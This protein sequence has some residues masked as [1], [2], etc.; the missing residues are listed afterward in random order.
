MMSLVE[1][2]SRRSMIQWMATQIGLSLLKTQKKRAQIMGRK[3]RQCYSGRTWGAKCA[4]NS[5]RIIRKV[6]FKT[7]SPPKNFEEVFI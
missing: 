6:T 3:G 4:K 7:R 2:L 1:V 5:H